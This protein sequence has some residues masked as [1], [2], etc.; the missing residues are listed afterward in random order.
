MEK[1]LSRPEIRLTGWSQPTSSIL[2]NDAPFPL[3]SR[4][5]HPLDSTLKPLSWTP[6]KATHTLVITSRIQEYTYVQREQCLQG[7]NPR[8][9]W[10]WKDESFFHRGWISRKQSLE[11]WYI[12]ISIVLCCNGDWKK[13]LKR[14]LDSLSS[15]A[16]WIDH[17]WLI[18]C[19]AIFSVTR[20]VNEIVFS[21]DILSDIYWCKRKCLKL[22]K[23]EYE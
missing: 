20:T 2:E 5:K 13:V 15:G 22:C 16:L 3:Y 11:V 6:F 19:F 4:R 7:Y 10:T 14:D 12:C 21:L 9:V 1:I 17:D 8:Y 18:S 23:Y